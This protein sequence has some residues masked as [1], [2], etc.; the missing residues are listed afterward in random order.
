MRCILLTLILCGGIELHSLFCRAVLFFMAIWDLIAVLCPFG[1]L[2][3]LVEM[4]EEKGVKIPDAVR[5]SHSLSPLA[6]L[7]LSLRIGL[8]PEGILQHHFWHY[9]LASYFC[10]ASI[11]PYS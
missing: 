4:T 7:S 1:P 3:L 10:C 5:L 8:T 6:M 11:P 9:P 2:R